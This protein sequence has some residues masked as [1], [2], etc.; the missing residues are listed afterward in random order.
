MSAV[1]PGYPFKFEEVAFINTVSPSEMNLYSQRP[2]VIYHLKDGTRWSNT[3]IDQDGNL[4][5]TWINF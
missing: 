5:N 3:V 2:I 4:E 1:P